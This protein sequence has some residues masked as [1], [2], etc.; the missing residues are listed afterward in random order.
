MTTSSWLLRDSPVNLWLSQIGTALADNARFRS[1]FRYQ[2]PR[3]YGE[4][5]VDPNYEKGFPVDTD[6][7]TW[8]SPVR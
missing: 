8:G 2:H 3:R 5:Q 7:W 4:V 1:R 6:L